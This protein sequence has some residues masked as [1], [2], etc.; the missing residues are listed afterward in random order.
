MINFWAACQSRVAVQPHMSAGAA[1]CPPLF[2][3][4][5]EDIMK[6]VIEVCPYCAS[7]CKI[8]LLVE[9][10][11]VVGA[12]GANGLT[13][14]GALCLKGL[15]GWDF[16]NDT[17]ILTPRVKN[18]MIRRKRGG[19]LEAVSWDTAID[20]AASRLTAIKNNFGPDSIMVSGSSR[21]TGNETNYIMQ[22]FHI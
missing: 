3:R 17:K 8:N 15:Y 20:Y 14:Q 13:N 9:N 22:K 10:G 12:E 5:Q 2:K 1:E 7:G 16:I 6:K 11:R 4:I 19:E 18:P 21:S